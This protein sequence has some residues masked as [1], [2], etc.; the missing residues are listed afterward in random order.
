[1]MINNMMTYLLSELIAQGPSVLIHGE[2]FLALFVPWMLEGRIILRIR[3]V[4]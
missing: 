3:Q 1:M 4:N 2:S